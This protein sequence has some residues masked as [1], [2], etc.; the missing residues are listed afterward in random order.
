LGVVGIYGC[1][2]VPVTLCIRPLLAAISAGN[3]AFVKPSE[4]SPKIGLMVKKLVE[5]YM[6]TKAFAVVNG[7][8]ELAKKMNS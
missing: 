4:M 8:M 1:W 7:G 2:N 5:N 6:D 3:C